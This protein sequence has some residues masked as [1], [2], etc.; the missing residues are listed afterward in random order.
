MI[1]K[2]FSRLSRRNGT[3][4][5]TAAPAPGKSATDETEPREEALHR[6]IPR[7]DVPRQVDPFK[8]GL[9]DDHL[10]GW[11]NRETGCIIGDFRI[12]PGDIVLDVG[13]GDGGQANF[14]AQR[15]AHVILADIDETSLR[16]AQHRLIKTGARRVDALLSDST[17]LPIPDETAT[18]IISSEVIEHVDDPQAVLRELARAGK[19]GAYYLLT[20]PDAA[21][22]HMQEGIAPSI[23]F[24]KPNHVRIIE[25]EQFEQMVVAAGLVVEQRFARG[26]YWNLWWLF[27]WICEQQEQGAPL[28]PLLQ[29]WTD[30][31]DTLTKMDRGLEVKTALDNSLPRSQVLIARK[32]L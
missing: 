15:G 32:P 18:R 6:D 9:R 13:C 11:F 31:W 27:F 28:P 16:Q 21:A 5:T 14:C 8:L 1:R 30:T 22:E 20:A 25:R 4:E 7:G 29:N 12:D 10:G 2:L 17:P 23:Y 26:F 24:E 19:P 3:H